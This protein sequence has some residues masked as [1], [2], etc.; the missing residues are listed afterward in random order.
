MTLIQPWPP[1]IMGRTGPIWG[2]YF[3]TEGS[4]PAR[5]FGA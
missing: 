2:R 4:Q 5:A 1:S 3:W